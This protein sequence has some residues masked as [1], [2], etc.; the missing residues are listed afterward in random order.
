MASYCFV[1][2]QGRELCQFTNKISDK[3]DC[4][5]L[6]L[7]CIRFVILYFPSR[8][9]HSPEMAQCK[10]RFSVGKLVIESE[11]SRRRLY[12]FI[13][14]NKY[15]SLILPANLKIDKTTGTPRFFFYHNELTLTVVSHLIEL[16]GG[17][18]ELVKENGRHHL[19]ESSVIKLYESY[20]SDSEAI[21]DNEYILLEHLLAFEYGYV[22]HDNAPSQANGAIHPAC[23]FDLNFSKEAT[24]KYGLHNM[25]SP[26]RFIESFNES[27]DKLYLSDFSHSIKAI[28]L[29]EKV[30]KLFESVLIRLR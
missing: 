25:L 12:L 14:D 21:P 2:I 8:G 11:K 19:M 16:I 15:L 7:E 6:V 9:F 1:D 20:V 4:V 28:S 3:W 13:A 30:R 29:V 5:K 10:D 24:F 23:H 22:R 26:L 17:H 18:D 27:H